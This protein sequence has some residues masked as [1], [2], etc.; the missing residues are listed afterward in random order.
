MRANYRVG[1]LYGTATAG[2]L[3]TQE[4][5]SFIAAKELTT[6]QFVCLTQI[7]LLV[8]IPLLMARSKSRHD[9]KR[10]FSDPGHYWKFGVILAIGI[11]GLVL[12]NIG[13]AKTHPII[14]SVILNLSPFWAAL[15]ALIIAKVPIPISPVLFFFCLAGAFLG[16]MAVT[17]SQMDGAAAMSMDALTDNVLKGDWLY[18]LPVP[19]FYALSAT[20]I[21][22]WFDG[23]DESATIAANFLVANVVLIPTTVFL[24]YQRSE[25]SLDHW[26]AI[27]LMIVGTILAGS[28][29][30]VFYQV[31]ISVTAGDNGFVSMFF[32]LV[33]GADRSIVVLDGVVDPVTARR[34]RPDL[35]FRSCLHR[36]LAVRVFA[37]VV[38]SRAGVAAPGRGRPR[39]GQGQAPSPLPPS[40]IVNT[41][42]RSLRRA[43]A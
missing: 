39:E 38:A 31:A 19:F 41:G 16:A 25:L 36:G 14:V 29:A 8:S 12:Y 5:F 6:M 32:N 35:L 26:R 18:V 34:S 20:L 37:E 7:A 4:P 1:S 13:L 28:F 21:G 11:A 24:L 15:V 3:S 40:V 43:R 22:K 9:L 17:V 42:R 2:L 23:F 33:P 30:R 10:L 27:L